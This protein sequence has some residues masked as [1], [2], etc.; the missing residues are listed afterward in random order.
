MTRRRAEGSVADLAHLAENPELGTSPGANGGDAVDAHEA[1]QVAQESRNLT[2]G[3][4]ETAR[5]SE[6]VYP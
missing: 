3:G 6:G 2:R 4:A 5:P 1:T